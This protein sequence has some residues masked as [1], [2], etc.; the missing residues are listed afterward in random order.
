MDPLAKMLLDL[1]GPTTIAGVASAWLRQ[2]V[3]S[4]LA[5]LDALVVARRI[6]RQWKALAKLRMRT[7]EEENARQANNMHALRG[8]CTGLMVCVQTIAE[9][10]KLQLKLPD[11]PRFEPAR[12]I[13]GD[14]LVALLEAGE[15]EETER[16][17]KAV[18]A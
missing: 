6:D 10:Q 17:E 13:T 9:Q 5:D 3:K 11:P 8:Y 14:Q 4:R 12:T 16:E 15:L 2:W 7:L 1:L 18:K